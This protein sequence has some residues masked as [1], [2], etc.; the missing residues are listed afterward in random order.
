MPPPPACQASSLTPPPSCAHSQGDISVAIQWLQHASQQGSASAMYTLG[1][2][3]DHGIGEDA[4][5][6]MAAS[7]YRQAA[8]CGH[9]GALVKVR[10]I[11]RCCSVPLVYLI[12]GLR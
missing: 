9:P 12:A 2:C 10:G 7:L 8:D 4:N 5:K 1:Y 3:Y 6:S 11:G